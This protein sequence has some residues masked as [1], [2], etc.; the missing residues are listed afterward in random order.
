MEEVEEEEKEVVAPYLTPTP[1]SSRH[2]LTARL[3][4][5]PWGDS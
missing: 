4:P 3:T 2:T 5:P 1:T